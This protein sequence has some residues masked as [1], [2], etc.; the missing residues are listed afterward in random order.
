MTRLGVEPPDVAMPLSITIHELRV[1]VED[2]ADLAAI[3][4]L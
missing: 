3:E 4:V 1:V 2:I